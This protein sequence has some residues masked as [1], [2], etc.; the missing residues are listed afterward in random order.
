MES[1]TVTMD[2]AKIAHAAMMLGLF[3]NEVQS[4]YS[5]SNE[6]CISAVALAM[7]SKS[8]GDVKF[9]RSMLTRISSEMHGTRYNQPSAA[10]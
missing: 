5:L 2:R 9:F 10:H 6:E 8:R 1:E 4:K 3:M 7:A